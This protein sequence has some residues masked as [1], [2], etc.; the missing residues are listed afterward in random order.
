M[1]LLKTGVLF[2]GAIME[3]NKKLLLEE[4]RLQILEVCVVEGGD[5]L[6]ELPWVKLRRNH[7]EADFGSAVMNFFTFKM[8]NH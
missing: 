5:T 4:R 7:R 6:L 2:K 3:G 8:S 1:R